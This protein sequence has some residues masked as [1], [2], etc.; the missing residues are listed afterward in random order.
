MKEITKRNCC[1]WSRRF[2]SYGCIL[3]PRPQRHS[4]G[5]VAGRKDFLGVD[6]VFKQ[7][8]LCL[9]LL[10]AIFPAVISYQ[11]WYWLPATAKLWI[12]AMAVRKAPGRLFSVF[13]WPHRGHIGVQNNSEKSLLGIWFYYYAKLERH[14]AIVLYTNKAVSSREWKPRITLWVLHDN[15]SKKWTTSATYRGLIYTSLKPSISVDPSE[16]FQYYVR[17]RFHSCQLLQMMQ[18]GPVSYTHLT[19]PTKL[20]V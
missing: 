18:I 16:L 3:I 19:L 4:L 1:R 13:M 11:G 2:L 12:K 14:F 10:L 15:V 20:E 9:S 7:S 5:D 6:W 8:C 17:V